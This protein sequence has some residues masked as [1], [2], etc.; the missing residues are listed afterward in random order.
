MAIKIGINGFGRIGRLVFRA[1]F[2]SADIE[3][4][5]INDPFMTPDYLAY[6]LKYDTVHGRFQGEVSYTDDAIVVDGKTIKFF[7]QKDPANIP[8]GA[9]GVDYVVEATGIFLTKE[10]AQ[11]HIDGGAKKVVKIGRASWRDRV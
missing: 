8:W 6:M 4:V 11:P 3:I 9:S 1:G 5:G 10:S 2:N 7:A